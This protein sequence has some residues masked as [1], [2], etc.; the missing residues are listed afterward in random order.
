[1]RDVV[2]FGAVTAAHLAMS[3]G[4][5]LYTFG[6]GMARFD[7]GTPA[8]WTEVAARIVVSALGFPVL[9]LLER[10]DVLRFPGLWGYVPFVGNAA[11]WGLAVALVARHR[12][13]S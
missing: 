12:R 13:A 10:H 8:S 4:L 6:T 1:M 11:I 3:L 9:T 7:Q 5:L 2:V